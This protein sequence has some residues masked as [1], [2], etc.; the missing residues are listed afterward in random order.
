MQ[1]RRSRG[2]RGRSDIQT[3]FLR[4][5]FA[6]R[7]HA[8]QDRAPASRMAKTFRTASTSC[9]PHGRDRDNPQRVRG[10]GTETTP[11]TRSTASDGKSEVTRRGNI[12]VCDIARAPIRLVGRN[13]LLFEIVGEQ[14]APGIA[15]SCT[16]HAAAGEK[17]AE[18][19]SRHAADRFCSHET[20][21]GDRRLKHAF[22][23][24]IAIFCGRLR[25]TLVS[26]FVL[27]MR[28]QFKYR[29]R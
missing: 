19:K 14:A 6:E 18:C 26:L 11:M 8:S 3:R 24:K 7:R 5:S 29:S 10:P 13:L 27:R 17:L 23:G 22:F 4:R 2:P 28:I 16:G 12:A 1:S 9:P 21:T 25:I 20:R 15:E